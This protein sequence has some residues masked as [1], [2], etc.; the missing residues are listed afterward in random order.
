M[1]GASLDT[2]FDPFSSEN[3]TE[4]NNNTFSYDTFENIRLACEFHLP[5]DIQHIITNN[6]DKL[7]IMQ[8]TTILFPMT[9]LKIFVWL[10]NFTCQR[11]FN[12]S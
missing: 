7:N 5:K 10:V 11:I 9:H 3:D 8:I 1:N 6:K 2:I 12:T 4:N